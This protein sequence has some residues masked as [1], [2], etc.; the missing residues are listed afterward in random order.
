MNEVLNE[1][2]SMIFF[3]VNTSFNRFSLSNFSNDIKRNVRKMGLKYF[4]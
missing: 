1:L 2:S 3:M 4:Y